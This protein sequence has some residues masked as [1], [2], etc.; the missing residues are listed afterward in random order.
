MYYYIPLKYLLQGNASW[1]VAAQQVKAER[2]EVRGRREEGRGKREEGVN[3]LW[4]KRV[5]AFSPR[6]HPRWVTTAPAHYAQEH[7]FDLPIEIT[8]PLWYSRDKPKGED[9]VAY[10]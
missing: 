5:L 2:K 3:R 8:R 7:G 9:I 6:A 4:E 1:S 10:Q